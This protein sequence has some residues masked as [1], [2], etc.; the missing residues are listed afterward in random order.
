MPGS[1]SA[2]VSAAAAAQVGACG[3]IAAINNVFG[4][5]VLRLRS[6]LRPGGCSA[7]CCG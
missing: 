1:E 3:L 6:V 2:A 7:P 5:Y 4:D